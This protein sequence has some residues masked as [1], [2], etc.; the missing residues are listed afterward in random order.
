MT[1][2]FFSTFYDSISASR[3]SCLPVTVLSLSPALQEP[4]PANFSRMKDAQPSEALL[5]EEIV[6]VTDSKHIERPYILAHLSRK[7]QKGRWAGRAEVLFW[8]RAHAKA[9]KRAP[10]G[11]HKSP[12]H[13]SLPFR[14][15]A[16]SLLELTGH[17]A[18][19]QSPRSLPSFPSPCQSR[20]EEP[21]LS[22]FSRPLLR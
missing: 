6:T 19:I 20:G 8:R 10:H 14:S 15:W 3:M 2:P 1:E 16:K 18:I 5:G 21:S 17:Q 11:S 12:L 13:P 22:P 7:A 4:H 9:A